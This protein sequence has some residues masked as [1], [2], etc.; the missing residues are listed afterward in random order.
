MLVAIDARINSTRKARPT[1]GA[2]FTESKSA[3]RGF[4]SESVQEGQTISG[5][6]T[7]AT[8]L[9]VFELSLTLI[10]NY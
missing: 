4:G 8:K 6:Q 10:G 9:S 5:F 7:T 3:A 2:K 1:A